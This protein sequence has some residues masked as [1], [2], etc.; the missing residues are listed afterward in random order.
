M[1]KNKFL[2]LIVVFL[3]AFNALSDF[4]SD[5]KINSNSIEFL[6]ESKK[7]NFFD[8]VEIN[9]KYVNIKAESATYDQK[10]DVISFS[11]KPSIIKSK[12]DGNLFNGKA[13]KILFFNDEKVHL[14]GNASMKYEDISISSNIIIFNPQSGKMTSG[15]QFML[16]VKQITKSIKDKKILSQI[17]FEVGKGEIYGLL[18]PNGAGKTTTFYIIAG[19][20]NSEEGKILLLDE[21]ISDLPMHKRSKLGIKYLP[22]E[23]SIFQGLTVYENLRGLAELSLQNQN[24]IKEFIESS[25]EEFGLSEISNLKGRQLSGGQRRKVEI[26]RTLAAKPKVILMDEPFAGIDPI[27]IEDI[28]NVLKKLVDKNIGVLITDHNVRETLE[29]CNQAAIINNGEIIAE[30]DKDELINNKLVKKVYLGDMYN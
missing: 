5:I 8:S 9:S 23:P 10:E 4:K 17:S 12:K 1:K 14:I 15:W 22:Q 29:I 13:E 18:G 19:L 7:I 27:A 28:K 20:I 2:S 26:A 21:D 11:G 3:F 16:E 30:G 6:K 25:I 24:D